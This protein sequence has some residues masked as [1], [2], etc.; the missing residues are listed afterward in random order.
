MR[1]W[2]SSLTISIAIAPWGIQPV[3]SY[4]SND[5]VIA[6]AVNCKVVTGVLGVVKALGAPATSFCS[7][8]LNIPATSTVRTTKTS[9]QVSTVTAAPVV[10]EVP[11]PSCRAPVAPRDIVDLDKRA[12][13]PALKLYAAGEISSACACLSLKAKATTTITATAAPVKVT[14]TVTPT[15]TTRVCTGCTPVGQPCIFEHPEDCCSQT[16]ACFSQV[17][18]CYQV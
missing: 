8:Y 3:L 12:V 1:F 18:N 6:R 2:L 15:S 4:P 16:C 17:C 11:D 7:S 9:T 14:T 10:V 5:I 13:P